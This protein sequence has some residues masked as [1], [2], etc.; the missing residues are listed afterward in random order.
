[1]IIY[2]GVTGCYEC[3]ACGKDFFENYN[4]CPWCGTHKDQ[5]TLKDYAGEPTPEQMKIIKSIKGTIRL[6][7]KEIKTEFC[8]GTCK[9]YKGHYCTE[10]SRIHYYVEPQWT[11]HW[12]GK[13]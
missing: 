7:S 5:K 3:T 13:K 11:C 4:Y 9:H 6:V 1:M 2:N 10:N 12:K 8:C